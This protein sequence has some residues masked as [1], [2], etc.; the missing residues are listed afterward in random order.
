[1][2]TS[3]ASYDRARMETQELTR[4]KNDSL[5]RL[6]LLKRNSSGQEA[7][8]PAHCWRACVRSF[9]R[10]CVCVCVCVRAWALACVGTLVCSSSC[11]V[12]HQDEGMCKRK[13]EMATGPWRAVVACGDAVMGVWVQD[14]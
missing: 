7:S 13:R 6:E 1:M 8:P 12:V 9:V 3:A 2:L 4:L 11:R 14:G 10:A 5:A